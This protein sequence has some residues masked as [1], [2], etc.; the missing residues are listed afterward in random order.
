MLGAWSNDMNR[1]FQTFGALIHRFYHS[2][3]V[4]NLFYGSH[5]RGEIHRGIVSVLAGDVWRTDNPFQSMLLAPSRRNAWQLAT[6]D[7]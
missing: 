1:G 2:R 3:L 4:A 7:T 6:V 5:E